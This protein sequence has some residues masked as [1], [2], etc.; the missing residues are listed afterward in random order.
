MTKGVKP[1]KPYPEFPL[2][3][4]ASGKWAK[5]IQGKIAYF[6]S[7]DD[8]NEALR[9]YEE[10][11]VLQI[12][13]VPPALN[14]QT[15]CNAFL[16]AKKKAVAERLLSERSFTD[17]KRSLKRFAD[18]VGRDRNFE[19]LQ[20]RDF[21]AYKSKF[22]ETNN[23]VTVGNEITRIKTAINWLAASKMAKM[24]DVGP[25]FKK[26]SAKA[27]R[28][29]KREMGVKLFTPAQ[30]HAILDESG[31]RMKAMVLIGIN[32]GYHN[33]DCETISLAQLQAAIK[34]GTIEHAREKTE[35]ERACPLWPETIAA[36]KAWIDRRPQCKSK[37]AFVLPSG[38]DLSPVNCDVAKRFRAVRE[39]AEISDGGFSWLRKTFATFAGETGDQVA[40]N[41]IMGHVDGT[42][43]GIYRQLV[44]EHRLQKVVDHMRRWLFE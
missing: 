5:K 28:R 14:V 32:C 27:A 8:P 21:L 23:P 16:T 6:G 3:P 9:L 2:Y 41:F 25:D 35:V 24:P 1:E 37:R 22:A 20:P 39:A 42:V 38:R 7:W 33:S 10:S 11:L 13:N 30:I 26:P 15:A 40:V 44:R 4:H 12:E 18:F 19:N 34:T 43:P 29:H 36:L 17:Y 31:V